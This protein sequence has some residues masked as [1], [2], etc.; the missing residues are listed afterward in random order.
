M[1]AVRM[2]GRLHYNVSS[3]KQ[4]T[5]YAFCL[6]V[7]ATTVFWGLKTHIFEKG[8]QGATAETHQIQHIIVPTGTV[9]SQGDST[10]Y[11]RM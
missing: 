6:F 7:Y 5:F 9:Y 10:N 4:E 8:F 3:Q 11:W 1:G 2:R